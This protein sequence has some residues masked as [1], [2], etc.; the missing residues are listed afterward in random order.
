MFNYLPPPYPPPPPPF[1]PSLTSL[2]VSVDVK[3]H[4]YLVTASIP[5]SLLLPV[6]NKPCG[7]CGRWAPCLLSYRLHTPP[8]PF[9]PSLTSLVVSVDVEHHVYLVT[10]SIPPSPLLPVPNKPCGFCGRWAPCLLSYRL[11]T[12]PP[13]LLPVPNKPCGFCGRWV[14]CLLTCVGLR[15]PSSLEKGSRKARL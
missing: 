12:P 15:H 11:H 3:H 6:P 4:V 8:P 2:V 1:S 5:P 10:A 13:P 14:P 9:S 7:F